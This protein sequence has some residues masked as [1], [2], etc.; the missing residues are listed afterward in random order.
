MK[1]FTLNTHF[2]T[3][4]SD[5]SLNSVNTK[6][7]NIESYG[8]TEELMKFIK[9]NAAAVLLRAEQ[10]NLDSNTEEYKDKFNKLLS[11]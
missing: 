4:D 6:F 10:P 7:N 8:N 9:F 11:I 1:K 2:T 5:I 3:I